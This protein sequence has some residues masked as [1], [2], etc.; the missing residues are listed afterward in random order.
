MTIEKCKWV[1]TFLLLILTIGWAVF[2]VNAVKDS[3]VE[4]NSVNAVEAS[5]SSIL[6]GALIVWNGNVNQ[7]W[8]RKKLD[9]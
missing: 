6:L 7:H 2:T 5:G 9:E 1:Y 4:P 8:F 3:I